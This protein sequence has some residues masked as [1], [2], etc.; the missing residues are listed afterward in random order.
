MLAGSPYNE[1]VLDPF[2]GF[3]DIQARLSVVH[4][5]QGRFFGLECR[6]PGGS[7]GAK[8]RTSVDV[9]PMVEPLPSSGCMRAGSHPY[10]NGRRQQPYGSTV[11]VR[12]RYENDEN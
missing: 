8:S 2:E 12:F 1:V 4:A 11:A 5:S 3:R 10:S 9:V 7:L 6:L